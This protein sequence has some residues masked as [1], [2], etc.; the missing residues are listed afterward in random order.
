[1]V[2]SSVGREGR[3]YWGA[4]AV[5]KFALEGLTQVLADEHEHAGKIRVN[6]LNPGGTRTAMRRAAYPAEDPLTLPT[7]EDRLDLAL[8]LM[9]DQAVGITGQQFDARDWDGP[10]RA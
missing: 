6:S 1:M 10:G 8:Y 5:S 4:Y 3:A 2:S 7:P 9:T